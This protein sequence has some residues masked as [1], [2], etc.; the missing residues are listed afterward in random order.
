MRN[1]LQFMLLCVVATTATATATTASE[2]SSLSSESSSS[3]SSPSSPS[4]T[5][6]TSTSSRTTTRRRLRGQQEELSAFVTLESESVMMVAGSTTEDVDNFGNAMNELELVT[7][8][9]FDF[10]RLLQMGSMS[11]SMMSMSM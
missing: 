8:E 10:Y 6:S 3:P 1:I 5:S 9:D 2:S 7:A 4:S 11:M